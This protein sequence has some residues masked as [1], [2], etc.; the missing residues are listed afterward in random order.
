[1]VTRFPGPWVGMSPLVRVLL[2][3]VVGVASLGAALLTLPPQDAH[4]QS[5]NDTIYV[6][7]NRYNGDLR[8]TRIPGRCASTEVPL[9]MV[10][11]T[12]AD[13]TEQELLDRIQELED[14]LNNRIDTEVSDL[15]DTIDDE[16]S[17]LQSQIDALETRI[18]NLETR[19]TDLET[20]VSDLQTALGNLETEVDDLETKHDT[21]IDTLNTR[22]DNEVSSLTTM[23][24]S[25]G[26]F[27]SGVFDDFEA[28]FSETFDV[29]AGLPDIVLDP[30]ILEIE[31]LIEPGIELFPG[32]DLTWPELDV[33]DPVGIVD[34]LAN[35]DTDPDN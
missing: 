16:V 14:Q 7:A 33:I 24:N 18:S 32:F 21:D 23:I 34:C 35:V 4:A 20:D 27:F 29:F 17:D 10:S 11:K 5:S 9:E 30:I 28:C 31:G 25:L 26:T 8:V 19:A 22:I 1:M 13:D 12:G 6:C 3:L 2:V 15:N